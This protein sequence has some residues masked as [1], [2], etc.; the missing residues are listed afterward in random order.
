M[1]VQTQT[2]NDSDT[3]KV[4]EAIIKRLLFTHRIPADKKDAV[5]VI[6]MVEIQKTISSMSQ[7]FTLLLGSIAFITL[8]VGGIGIMNI[9]FVSV[10]ERT[11]EIGLRKAIGANNTDILFQFIIESVFVC[12]CGGIMGIL[13]GA[14]ASAVISK[15][16]G[17]TIYITFFSIGLALCFS[18][19]VGLV[20]GVWPA[21]KAALLNPIEALRHD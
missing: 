2:K 6:N 20:F 9:M 1:G 17:W 16:A 11:K 10:S 13:F 12:C 3:K 5:E 7:T 8:L 18:G 14:G 19:F 4:S 21:R 15:L